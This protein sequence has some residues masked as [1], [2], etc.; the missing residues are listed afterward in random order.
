[1]RI[2]PQIWVGAV[3]EKSL[4]FGGVVALDADDEKCSETVEI[5]VDVVRAF[6]DEREQG[7]KGSGR[8]EGFEYGLREGVPA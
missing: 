7:G 4:H 8:E 2:Q 6:G 3:R 1:M 5:G